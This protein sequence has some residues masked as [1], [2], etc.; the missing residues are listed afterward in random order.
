[1]YVVGIDTAEEE[2]EGGEEESVDGE[3]LEGYGNKQHTH[4][5]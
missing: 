2:E 5:G 3:M 4:G 1:M